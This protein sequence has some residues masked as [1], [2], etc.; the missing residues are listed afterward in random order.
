MSENL[1]NT[2]ELY[3]LRSGRWEL[4]DNYEPSEGE[5]CVEDA[6]RL[7]KQGRFEGVRVVEDTCD[8]TSRQA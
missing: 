2:F 5:K 4:H 3:V 6:K 1:T 7:H 8:P